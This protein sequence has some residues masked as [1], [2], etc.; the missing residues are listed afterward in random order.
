M[1]IRQVKHTAS[2]RAASLV[3]KYHRKI[4]VALPFRGNERVRRENIWAAG[5]GPKILFEALE[6]SQVRSNDN[7]VPGHR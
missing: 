6:H 7:E 5:L 1:N 4:P 2:G 3:L